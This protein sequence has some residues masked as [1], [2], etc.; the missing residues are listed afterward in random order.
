MKTSLRFD[1]RGGVSCLYTEAIDLRTI[2]RLQVVRATDIRFNDASQQ[3]EVRC[4]STDEVLHR[5]PSRA[6]CVAWEL[7]NL[8]PGSAAPAI[9][10]QPL[11][12]C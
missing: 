7:D 11:L 1:N 2:G 3:W 9:Q 5:Q 10:P 4:A 8:G 6:A 12:S